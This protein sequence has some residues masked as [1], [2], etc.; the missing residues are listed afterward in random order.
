LHGNV[1]DNLITPK[2][3]G[4]EDMITANSDANNINEKEIAS[5]NASLRSGD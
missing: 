4:E 5:I 3:K 1:T 2:K